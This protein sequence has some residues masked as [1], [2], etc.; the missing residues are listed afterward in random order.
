MKRQKIVVP[1]LI[2]FNVVRLLS[3]R[4]SAE[5]LSISK[6]LREEMLYLALQGKFGKFIDAAGSEQESFS[7]SADEVRVAGNLANKPLIVLTVS[8]REAQREN[9]KEPLRYDTDA[10][11]VGACMGLCRP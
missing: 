4:R 5:G 7:Q 2:R 9:P 1:I 10:F 6:D 3:S 11:E 8:L